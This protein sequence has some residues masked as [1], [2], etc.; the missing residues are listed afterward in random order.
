M[1]TYLYFF[2]II[3]T[4]YLYYH[5]SKKNGPELR[6]PLIKKCINPKCNCNPCVCNPCKCGQIQV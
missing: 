2:P 6:E 4:T 5:Y 1:N 3:V